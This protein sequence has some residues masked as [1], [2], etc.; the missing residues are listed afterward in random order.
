[1]KWAGDCPAGL[2]V[3]IPDR[4]NAVDCESMPVTALAE[5]ERARVTCL[6]QPAS[7]A[8]ARLSALGLLPGVEIEVIQRFPAF[9]FRIGHAEVA[10]DEALAGL[11]R[12][13]KE[14]P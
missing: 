1:M 2:P 6:Q 5:G 10:V 13:N 8:A 9:V 14:I 11:I 12:T 3:P 4:C 7:A